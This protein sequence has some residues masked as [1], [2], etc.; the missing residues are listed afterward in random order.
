MLEFVVALA[1]H[2]R[3][4]ATGS[5]VD[6][7]SPE[8]ERLGAAGLP[9][10]IAVEDV[11]AADPTLVELLARLMAAAQSRA[12]KRAAE[13][14]QKRCSVRPRSAAGCRRRRPIAGGGFG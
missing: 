14:E 9:I 10:V 5:V 12:A 8:L 1:H 4:Q 6:E 7:L 13:G 11:H 3:Q 2:Q